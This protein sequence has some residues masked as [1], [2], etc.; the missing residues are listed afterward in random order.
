MNVDH[1]LFLTFIKPIDVT[2]QEMSD[3]TPMIKNLRRNNVNFY[4]FVKFLN[5]D[6]V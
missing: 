5:K 3:S 1:H 6:K 4:H 2:S